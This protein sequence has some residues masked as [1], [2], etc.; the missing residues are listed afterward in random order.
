MPRKGC[1]FQKAFT[2]Q[3][4]KTIRNQTKDQDV[5][6]I[7]SSAVKLKTWADWLTFFHLTH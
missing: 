6:S 7:R 2:D 1:A 4:S 3:A 5:C